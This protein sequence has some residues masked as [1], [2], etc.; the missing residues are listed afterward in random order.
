[1]RLAERVDSSFGST[2]LFSPESRFFI[3]IR[4]VFT[5]S[6]LLT[7]PRPL[8]SLQMVL[9]TSGGRKSETFLRNAAA[10]HNPLFCPLALSRCS[11]SSLSLSPFKAMRLLKLLLSTLVLATTALAASSSSSSSSI[12]ITTEA[13]VKVGSA[14]RFQW[15]VSLS[16]QYR[17]KCIGIDACYESQVWRESSLFAQSIHQ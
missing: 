16:R 3:S 14:I 6:A 4:L 10:T 15:C 1:M 9:Q 13:S 17:I 2:P 8:Y 11:L 7:N 5:I 12:S